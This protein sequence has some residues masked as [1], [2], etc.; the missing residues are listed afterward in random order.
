M[1]E[2]GVNVKGRKSEK[3]IGE[4]DGQTKVGRKKDEETEVLCYRGGEEREEKRQREMEEARVLNVFSEVGDYWKVGPFS[5]LGVYCFFI[6]LKSKCEAFC[7]L[8]LWYEI[9]LVWL[10]LF[11]FDFIFI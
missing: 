9:S 5:S 4:G 6:F 10:I 2:E 7:F 1:G 11:L 3:Q 8:N